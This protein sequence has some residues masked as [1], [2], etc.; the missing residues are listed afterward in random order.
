MLYEKVKKG[1]STVGLKFFSNHL[2]Y[3]NEEASILAIIDKNVDIASKK[4]I[5]D[6]FKRENLDIG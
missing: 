1:I 5:I 3:L 6:N 2:W 4:R